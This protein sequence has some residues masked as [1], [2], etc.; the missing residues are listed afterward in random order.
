MNFTSSG[1]RIEQS[2]GSLLLILLLA[3]TL[4]GCAGNRKEGKGWFSSWFGGK[5]VHDDYYETEAALTEK[6]MHYYS[7]SRY[8]MAEEIFQEIKDRFPF[9]D[10]A[11]LAELRLADCK[12]HQGLYEEAIP[13][14]EE[15]EKLHPANNAIPYVIFQIGSSY[16]KLM[17]YPDRDQ[18]YTKKLIEVYERLVKRYPDSPFTFE[19]RRRI[20]EARNRL[21]EHEIIV[22]Q[23]YLNTGQLPQAT[24]RLNSVLDL[25]PE[26]PSAEQARKLLIRAETTGGETLWE[27]MNPFD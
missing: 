13:L 20:A 7:T 15:F 18:T 16:Y 12:Y 17:A 23:W 14:Y 6:A 10:Y 11:K 25:Y 4:S 5:D 2:V 9:S 3:M 24:S 26:T 22:A 8:M 1:K 19:A 21:A 27:R